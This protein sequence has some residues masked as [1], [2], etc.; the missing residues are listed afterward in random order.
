MSGVYFLFVFSFF[1]YREGGCFRLR[2]LF[3]EF[4][5]KIK[6]NRPVVVIFIIGDNISPSGFMAPF[7]C[8]SQ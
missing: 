1:L 2:L 8:R 4:S 6:E 3:V 5:V 7:I